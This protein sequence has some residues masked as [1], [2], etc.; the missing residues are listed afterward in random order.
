MIE[1]HEQDDPRNDRAIGLFI[2]Q[3]KTFTFR[4]SN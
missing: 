1:D 4:K 2:E 3:L